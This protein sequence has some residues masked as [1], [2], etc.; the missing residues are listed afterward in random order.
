MINFEKRKLPNGLRVILAPFAGTEAATLL[1]LIKTGSRNETKRIS[2]ISHF[3]EH[4]FFKG[5][6][7]RPEAGMVHKELDRIGADHNAFT[8]K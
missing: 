2:G 6:K 1:A 4:M 7:S 8:S 5:T 3:L